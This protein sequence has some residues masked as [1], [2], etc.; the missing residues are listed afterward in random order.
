MSRTDKT[1]P[2]HVR[3]A[4][5]PGD[6]TIES[7]NHSKGYCDLPEFG[8][9]EIT[10]FGKPVDGGWS[11]HWAYGNGFMYGAGNPCG[12]P[13]CVDQAGRKAK[14]RKSRRDGRREAREVFFTD[15]L[16]CEPGTVGFMAEMQSSQWHT[17]WDDHFKFYG[18]LAGRLSLPEGTTVVDIHLFLA[19]GYDLP[20]DATEDLWVAE[21]YRISDGERDY[22]KL[23]SDPW[24][25]R[26]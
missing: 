11:C 17:S 12:C 19:D 22:V 9:G 6:T 4:D 13:M 20:Y 3:A 1:R 21:T 25:A 26:T 2:W 23:D 8:V 18:E 15:P 7:H 10:W 24:A 16:E 5:R 14:A